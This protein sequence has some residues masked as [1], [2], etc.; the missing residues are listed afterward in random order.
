MHLTALAF[1]SSIA[2]IIIA[3]SIM[4]NLSGCAGRQLVQGGKARVVNL[5][6]QEAPEAEVEGGRGRGSEEA[7]LCPS[8]PFVPKLVAQIPHVDTRKMSYI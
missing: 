1:I 6:L 7:T 3:G 4:G 8:D 2:L 5:G